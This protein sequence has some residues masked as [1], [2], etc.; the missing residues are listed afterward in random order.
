MIVAD[1]NLI[2]YFHIP[3]P[4]QPAAQDVLRRDAVWAAPV[5]W[6]SEFCSI[7]L[8]YLG[9]GQVTITGALQYLQQAESML[10]GGEH[11]ADATIVLS[12]AHT[13]GISSYDAEFVFL[14]QHLGVPLVT[15]DKRLLLAFPRLAVSLEDFVA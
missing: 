5:L 7:L 11:P 10:V 14:A 9:A 6:R 13:A 2:A 12:L 8:K 3:G 15:A 4:Q 1:S